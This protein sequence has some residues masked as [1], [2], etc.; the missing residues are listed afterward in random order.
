MLQRIL[1]ILTALLILTSVSG[2]VS[3]GSF[4]PNPKSVIYVAEET[5][6]YIPRKSVM[7]YDADGKMMLNDRAFYIPY[8]WRISGP[9]E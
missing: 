6:I 2:C 8:G 7:Y 5:G 9:K 1:T 4:R 3:R